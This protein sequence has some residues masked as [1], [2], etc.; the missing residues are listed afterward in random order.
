MRGMYIVG[1]DP[2]KRT[3]FA[4]YDATTRKPHS[5]GEL[6]LGPELWDWLEEIAPKAGT[7]VVEDYI[8]RPAHVAG[9]YTHAWNKGEAL[10]VIGAIE[11]TAH[12]HA[13]P[14]VRQQPAIKPIAAKHSGLPYDPKKKGR[15]V[16]QADAMLHVEHFIRTDKVM[17]EEQTLA[18]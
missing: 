5:I 12:Q 11:C 13:I 3:G 8:V 1:F 6:E 16:H 4:V 17:Q 9:G 18:S 7:F 2:G 14:V 10:Q 15:G